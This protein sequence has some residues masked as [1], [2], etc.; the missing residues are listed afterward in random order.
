MR[1]VL[2]QQRIEEEVI[3]AGISESEIEKLIRG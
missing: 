3:G 2:S 1:R